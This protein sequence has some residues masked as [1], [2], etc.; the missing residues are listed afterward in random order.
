MGLPIRTPPDSRSDT[1][2]QLDMPLNMQMLRHI[3]NFFA[4]TDTVVNHTAVRPGTIVIDP[5]SYSVRRALAR[6][7]A[8]CRQ[9]RL[10]NSLN[11]HVNDSINVGALRQ[12]SGG[13]DMPARELYNSLYPN[14]I[15]EVDLSPPTVL[16]ADVI[17]QLLG[18][19]EILPEQ[20]Q[21]D[22]P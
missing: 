10:V 19:A 6:Q 4:P 8:A 16:H 17:R 11:W 9:G 20:N 1:D 15:R 7:P 3:L 5:V 14:V 12:M 21:S 18:E 22:Q 2:I 13:D